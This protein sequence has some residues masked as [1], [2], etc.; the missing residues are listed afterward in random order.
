MKKKEKISSLADDCS[1]G[2]TEEKKHQNLRKKETIRKK[3]KTKNKLKTKT[4][5]KRCK[6]HWPM[7]AVRGRRMSGAGGRQLPHQCN[8]KW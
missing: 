8:V 1:E 6:N 3:L 4:M 5:R 7:T 2:E